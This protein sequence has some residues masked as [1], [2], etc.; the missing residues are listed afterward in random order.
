M[1][2]ARTLAGSGES[3]R[4][5]THAALALAVSSTALFLASMTLSFAVAYDQ[6]AARAKFTLM[7]S[8][9]VLP[10]ALAAF[11]RQRWET[12]VGVSGVVCAFM[13]AGISASLWEL[14]NVDLGSVAASL[15]VLVPLG[16][17]GLIW[18]W[19]RQARVLAQRVTIC[20]F[21]AGE[22]VSIVARPGI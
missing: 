14:K 11:A 21:L 3:G 2:Q 19:T 9:L 10:L 15:I 20:L 6:P 4:A 13:A 5:A 1:N 16:G 18:A 17:C 7:L 8:G 22:A 12:M